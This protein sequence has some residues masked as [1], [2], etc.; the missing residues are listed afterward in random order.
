[1]E[2]G[3]LPWQ[4]KKRTR[5]MTICRSAL[6]KPAKSWQKLKA[7]RSERLPEAMKLGV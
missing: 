7:E 1:M 5:E 3:G 2:M 4:K 6:I